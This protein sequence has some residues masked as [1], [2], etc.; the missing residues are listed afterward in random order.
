MVQTVYSDIEHPYELD[1]KSAIL[2]HPEMFG[3]IG[4]TKVISEKSI[5]EFNVIADLLVFSS[6]KGVIGIEIKT[7]HDS[8]QRLNKQLR[9]YEAICTEVWVFTHDSLYNDVSKVLRANKHDTVGVFTYSV[10]KGNIFFGKMKNSSISPSFKVD[11]LMMVLWKNE[12]LHIARSISGQTYTEKGIITSAYYGEHRDGHSSSVTGR[13][14]KRQLINYIKGRI[15]ALASYQVVVDMFVNEVK[16]P[17]K[18]IKYYYFKKVEESN[19]KIEDAYIK[20][21]KT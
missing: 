21:K 1:V 18:V 12:L 5:K 6:N 7:E 15:G 20:R 2:K 10:V 13:A 8:T 14:N 9:A 19:V 16:D 3:N 11:H 4:D 17:D